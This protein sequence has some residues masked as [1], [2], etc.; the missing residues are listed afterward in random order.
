VLV[1]VEQNDYCTCPSVAKRTGSQ[2]MKMLRV[3]DDEEEDLRRSLVVVA[4]DRL[5]VVEL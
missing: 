3:V 1:D 2:V 5:E 4:G